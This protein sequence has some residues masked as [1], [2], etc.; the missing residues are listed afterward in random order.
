MGTQCAF[1]CPAASASLLPPAFTE[2]KTTQLTNYEQLL[3]FLISCHIIVQQILAGYHVSTANMKAEQIWIYFT[4]NLHRLFGAEQNGEKR[5][6][7]SAKASPDNLYLITL[8]LTAS[9]LVF[10]KGLQKQ[11]LLVISSLKDQSQS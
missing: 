1:A 3:L 11:I 9:S 8:N 2:L 7:F 5:K 6:P 10:L 4:L